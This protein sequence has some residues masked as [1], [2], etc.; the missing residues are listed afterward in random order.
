M[1]PHSRRSLR[2]AAAA[3]ASE[4]SPDA[5]AH[6]SVDK[7]NYRILAWRSPPNG[8]RRCSSHLS[9]H[10]VKCTRKHNHTASPSPQFAIPQRGRKRLSRE[11]TLHAVLALE[12]PELVQIRRCKVQWPPTD[13]NNQILTSFWKYKTITQHYLP[14]GVVSTPKRSHTIAVS[15]TGLSRSIIFCNSSG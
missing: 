5:H 1:G 2:T 13:L 14:L 6:S 4:P 8:D 7:T 10:Q 15:S 3:I 12:W 11:A 9:H